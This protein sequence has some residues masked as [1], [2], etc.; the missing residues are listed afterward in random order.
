MSANQIA[1]RDITQR[2]TYYRIGSDANFYIPIPYWATHFDI[3]VYANGG[4]WTNIQL[5]H[6]SP[7]GRIHSFLS[8]GATNSY[9]VFNTPIVGRSSMY[10]TATTSYSIEYA[11][12]FKR[13]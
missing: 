9:G 3:Y 12:T 2:V 1:S 11:I 6:N 5:W 13:L 4:S 10:L 7:L 8:I